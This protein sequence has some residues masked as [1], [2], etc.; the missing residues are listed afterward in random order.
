MRSFFRSFD[1][2]FENK[3]VVWG[4]YKGANS[5]VFFPIKQTHKPRNSKARYITKQQYNVVVI[6]VYVVACFVWF[7]CDNNT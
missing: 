3:R 4:V 1:R 2:S 7:F 5:D 6:V